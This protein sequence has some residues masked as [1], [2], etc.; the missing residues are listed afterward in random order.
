MHW[1]VIGVTVHGFAAE[2]TQMLDAFDDRTSGLA[3]RVVNDDVMG[4]R[5]AGDYRIEDGRL[6][7]SG[8][9]DT[10]GG[11]F[12][13]LRS[14][15]RE[16]ELGAGTG[17]RLRVRGDGRRYSLGV[18]TAGRVNYWAEF[19][20]PQAWRVITLPF[21]AFEPR[22]RGRRLDGPPLDRAAIVGI[23]LMIADRRDGPFRLEVD[24]IARA[25]A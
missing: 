3:W 5:S 22:F 24:W 13:S 19:V 14:E 12:A 10:D 25:G 21:A 17:I 6:I 7:F 20:A 15:P 9:L 2:P 16:L 23:N 1:L 4:G 8:N 18:Q 11:G